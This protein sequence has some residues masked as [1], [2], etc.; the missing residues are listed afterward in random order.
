MNDNVMK[1]D[2]IQKKSVAI[3][4]FGYL[5]Y[6]TALR[7]QERGFHV[8]IFDFDTTRFDNFV[9]GLYPGTDQK[10]RWSSQYSIPKLNREKITFCFNPT[11]MFCESPVHFISLPQ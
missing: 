2:F 6:T 5:G 9:K 7:M 11:Q 4:G 10:N 8:Y 3:W 1:T